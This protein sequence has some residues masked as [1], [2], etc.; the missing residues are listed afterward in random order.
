MGCG[1]LVPPSGSALGLGCPSQPSWEEG[2]LA[3]PLCVPQFLTPSGGGV[4]HTYR[5]LSISS[6]G[7]RE[8]SAAAEVKG[9]SPEGLSVAQPCCVGP[10]VPQEHL[11]GMHTSQTLP[12]L[13]C[14]LF[15]E[16]THPSCCLSPPPWAEG[17]FACFQ[18]PTGISCCVNVSSGTVSVGLMLR[19]SDWRDLGWQGEECPCCS[20]STPRCALSRALSMHHGHIP[21]EDA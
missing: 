15:S 13:S 6:V 3:V 2:F 20:L 5:N 17:G 14:G 10:F 19:G 12:C 9:C 21:R 18:L 8:H 16:E 1:M 11:W 4:S 7:W